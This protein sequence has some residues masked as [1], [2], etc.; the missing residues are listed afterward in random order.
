VDEA[1]RIMDALHA[2]DPSNM[3]WRINLLM[4]RSLQLAYQTD[5]VDAKKRLDQWAAVATEWAEIEKSTKAK[6][7]PT[8]LSERY[9]SDL[10]YAKALA[11]AGRLNDSM[12]LFD[13]VLAAADA[14][15]KNRPDFLLLLIYVEASTSALQ[16]LPDNAEFAMKRHSICNGLAKEIQ[17]LPQFIGVHRKITRAWNTAQSCLGRESSALKN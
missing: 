5:T 4:A 2:Q 7:S 11:S 13:R 6:E 1:V 17:K 8:V 15:L 14:G 10:S 3:N 9:Q 12:D 16:A